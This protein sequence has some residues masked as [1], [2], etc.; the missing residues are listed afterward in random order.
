MYQKNDNEQKFNVF[1][2]LPHKN[3]RLSGYGVVKA[4]CIKRNVLN[5]ITLVTLSL[6]IL[7]V[8]KENSYN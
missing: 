8:I 1:L 2:I 5:K 6:T 4:A 3:C 7:D